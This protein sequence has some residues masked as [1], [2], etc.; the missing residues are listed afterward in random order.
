MGE[1]I[2]NAEPCTVNR[3]PKDIAQDIVDIDTNGD[4]KIDDDDGTSNN[5]YQT[6]QNK[7]G[8]ISA[9]FK[10]TPQIHFTGSLNYEAF[11]EWDIESEFGVSP[12]KEY[13]RGKERTWS[14][15]GIIYKPSKSVTFALEGNF[16]EAA[17]DAYA[18]SRVYF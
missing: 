14:T 1:R 10:Y 16:G 11:E 4:G 3:C 17:Q 8:L 15:I 7:G 5:D 12:D 18:Y 13:S 6:L 9:R 2:L